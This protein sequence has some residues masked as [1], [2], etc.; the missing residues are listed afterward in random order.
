MADSDNRSP[1]QL[2]QVT[3]LN[4]S[5]LFIV[6]IDVPSA[7][8]TRAIKKSDIITPSV[9][10][11]ADNCAQLLYVGA[12]AY[13]VLPGSAD[14][15]G[16][17]LTWASNIART[18]LSLTADT[19]YNVYLYSNSGTPAVEESTTAPVWDSTLGY[20][21]KT[22]DDTRRFI[23]FINASATNTIRNFM[24]VV[25]GTRVSEIIYIDGSVTGKSAVTSGSG[26]SS[27]T[28]FSLST[29]V[30]LPATHYYAIAKLSGTA[31]NDDATAGISP[32]DL[33]SGITGNLA[34][35]IV[36]GDNDVAGSSIFFG[37]TWLSIYTAQTGYYRIAHVVGTGSLL[38]LQV[39]GAR[40]LR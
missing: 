34:P 32:T 5:D 17:I 23:G 10:Y 11:I 18:S 33:G 19:L 6:S 4:D 14:V 16:T 40:F 24:H 38:T 31:A 25:T 1:S 27:W 21:K 8:K 29:L 39:H 22:G 3:T 13:S 2:T 26:A 20:Y 7:P 35:F 36:R 12:Q 9:G 28:S 30:P 15:N 37:S